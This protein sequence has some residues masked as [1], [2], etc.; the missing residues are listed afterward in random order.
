M[1]LILL[2]FLCYLSF[3][4]PLTFGQTKGE[5]EVLMPQES[6]MHPQKILI[7]GLQINFVE[8]GKGQPILFLHG[9][10]G[11]WKDWA[12]NLSFFPTFYQAM[13]I[14]FPGFGDSDKPETD[15]SISWL[16]T[17]VEKFLRERKLDQAIVVG[18][19]MGGLVAL[20]LAAQPGSPVKNLVVADVVGIGDKAEFLSYALTKKIMGPES[21]FE[22]FEGLLREEFKA[23]VENFIK[24][25]KPKT[26]KEFFQ[27]V[28]KNPLT[29]K[30]LLPMTPAVQMS[31]SIIDFDIRPQLASIR[32]PTLILWGS[33]DPIAPPQDASFL[34]S[35]IPQASL[36]ILENCGHSPMQ[37][38]PD[39]FNQEVEKFL[40]A[41]ESGSSR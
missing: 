5:E 8:E 30:P 2:S 39:R 3:L 32:Q 21:R 4:A 18:H 25:Q 27:S 28:P 7:A 36:E 17:I 35:K 24:G 33:K 11:S 20:N 38:L 12:A 14:D 13:A 19:S 37:D 41:A 1:R 15:Y 31:A 40:Q 26:S 6:R 16:T 22:T 23:M 34:K 10:G 9:L 29:G